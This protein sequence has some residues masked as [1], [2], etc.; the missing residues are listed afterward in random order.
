MANNRMYLKNQTTGKT[1]FIGKRLADGWYTGANHDMIAD[2]LKR[3]YDEA[4]F[5]DSWCLVFEEAPMGGLKANGV[6]Q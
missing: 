4:G 6:E 5:D 3:M 1:A 2:D